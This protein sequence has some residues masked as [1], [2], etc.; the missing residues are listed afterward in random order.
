VRLVEFPE[1][2]FHSSVHNVLYKTARAAY[3]S[4]LGNKK[5]AYG[6]MM[7]F[8]ALVTR[9]RQSCCHGGLVPEEARLLAEDVLRD[10]ENSNMT[11]GDGAFDLD[12]EEG[13]ALLQKILSCLNAGKEEKDH[14]DSECAVCYDELEGDNAC[15]LRK[16]QHVLCGDCLVAIEQNKGGVG[17]CPLC[18]NPFTKNDIIKKSV[19]EAA[20]KKASKN[21]KKK[22]QP[23]K[24]MEHLEGADEMHPKEEAVLDEICKM[25]P[26]E[27]AVIFSEWTSVLDIKEKMLTR[28]GYMCTRID[29]S[30][31]TDQRVEAMEAFASDEKDSPRVIL[32]SLMAAGTGITLT[33]G[34]LAIMIEPWWNFSMESQAMDRIYRIGQVRPV[35]CVRLIMEDSIEERMLSKVQEGKTAL[36]KGSLQKLN[37]QERSKAKITAMK[38][39]ELCAFAVLQVA[40][41]LGLRT[42][43]SLSLI[44]FTPSPL[45]TSFK[46]KRRFR[47][48]RAFTTTK[49]ILT[50]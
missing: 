36:G 37:A 2:G 19:A 7:R 17:H 23:K 20:A 16:C 1:E 45:Q 49:M 50:P 32:C 6:N 10:L 43:F 11:D 22:A 8:L 18:R 29:G 33:R 12:T 27:K 34:N 31:N 9:V 4:M 46:S 25:K 5:A 30:M 26:D 15:V 44:V 13:K 41:D 24:K 3:V 35:K 39:T 38:G 42:R 47:S 40:K 48:G 28:H 21:K 14:Y